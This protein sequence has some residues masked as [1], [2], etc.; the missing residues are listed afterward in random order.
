MLSN[1]KPKTNKEVCAGYQGRKRDRNDAAD[2]RRTA[3]RTRRQSKRV[4]PA[5]PADELAAW[6][7]KRLKVPPGH[8]RAGEP[9]ELPKFAVDFLRRC[10]SA[11]L[12]YRLVAGRS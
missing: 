7:K 1:M 3:A 6:T 12:S 9:M 5:K 2:R 4:A 11:G 8:E 10:T